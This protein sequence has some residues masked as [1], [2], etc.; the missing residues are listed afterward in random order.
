[1]P[2]GIP[3]TEEEQQRRRQQIY[4]A[5]IPLFLQQG[6][7]ETSMRQIAEA[8]GV[9]KSTLY[10]YF[11]SKDE[12]MVSYFEQEMQKMTAAALEINHQQLEVTEKV[13]R[14]ISNHLAYLIDN[15][16]FY[17]RLTLEAQ[18]LSA[19][20]QERIQKA[21]H[22]YQDLFRDLIEQG[23]RQGKF[24]AVDPLF[25]TRS[26][27]AMLSAVVFTTRPTGSTDEMLDQAL[28]IFF[29]GICR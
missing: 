14:V 13:R 7:I 18:R 9:G 20:S 1:M 27:F 2:K 3:L 16:H 12:I 8:A 21:R 22:A 28:G 11:L 17:L 23:I 24:R 26:I 6:F 19:E 5:A 4:A 10:D 15:K 29:D 25:A